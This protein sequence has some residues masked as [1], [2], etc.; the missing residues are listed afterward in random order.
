MGQFDNNNYNK[1]LKPLARNLRKDST[2]SEIKLW[3]EVLRAKQMLGFSFLRQRTIDNY[4]ADFFCKELKLIIELD[5]VTHL[6][7]HV[8]A[9]DEKKEKSLKEASDSILRFKDE[10]VIK[11]IEHVAATIEEWIKANHADK[12]PE[13]F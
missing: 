10:D 2:K 5:G 7:E 9:K 13:G 8:A 12:L 1:G 4:I 11:H 6:F 3:S